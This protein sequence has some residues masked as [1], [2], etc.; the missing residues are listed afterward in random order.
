MKIVICASLDFT[1][2]IKEIADKLTEMGHE[3]VIPKTSKM[4]LKGE[5]SLEQVMEEKG[6]RKFSERMKEHDIL[7]Y[8]FGK[9]KE[10]DALLVLNFDKK[11]I[12][13]YIGGGALIEMGFAHVLDK[14]IFL[15]NEIPKI[16]YKDEIVAMNPTVINNDLNK[17]K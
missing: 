12:K 16:S 5:V 2:K 4:I 6:T 14:K 3:V 17:I 13:N 10:G 11:G 1:E 15:W 9:I 7:K 8:Y